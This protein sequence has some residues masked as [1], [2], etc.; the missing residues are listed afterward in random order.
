MANKSPAHR[1]YLIRVA[2]ASAVYVLTV[3]LAMHVFHHGRLALPAAIGLSLFPSIPIVAIIA[4]V[5]LYLKEEKDEFQ[6]ELFIKS[7][8]WGTGATLAVTSFWSFLHIFGHVPPVDGFHV[9]ILFWLF[10]GLSGYPLHRY[11]GGSG[12]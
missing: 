12:E 10:V 9:F 11:Y 7:L 3:F 1:R 8:L 2:I 5:G 6:R 4:I